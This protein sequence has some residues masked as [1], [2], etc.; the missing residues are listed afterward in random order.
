MF[1]LVIIATMVIASQ[2]VYIA[3][4]GYNDYGYGYNGHDLTH[5]AIVEPVQ[6]QLGYGL[7]PHVYAAYETYP[8]YPSIHHHDQHDQDDHHAPAKYSFNYGVNDPHTGDVKS[9]HEERDGD[10][11]K[12][13]YSLNEPDGTIRVVDYT[14]DPH[15]GFNA[16]VKKIGHAVHPTPIVKHIVPHYPAHLHLTQDYGY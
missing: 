6:S 7:N 16:V 3:H 2:A 9:Q 8:A 5:A 10:V 1:K 14:A 12:G 15:N 11:V 4:N 13:S